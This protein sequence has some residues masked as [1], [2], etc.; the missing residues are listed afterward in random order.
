MEEGR[1]ATAPSELQEDATCLPS[2]NNIIMMVIDHRPYGRIQ[3]LL[4][5]HFAEDP[6]RTP[7]PPP[8]KSKLKMYFL[9]SLKELQLTSCFDILINLVIMDIIQSF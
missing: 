2:R 9:G 5:L 6:E 4:A 8:G 1:E 3:I 7:P